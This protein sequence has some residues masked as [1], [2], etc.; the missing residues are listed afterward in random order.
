RGTDFL[1]GVLAAFLPGPFLFGF[2]HDNDLSEKTLARYPALLVPNG[3]Y[4]ADESC[5]HIRAYVQAGGSLL[6]TFETAR[7]NE[8]GD[9]R[10][11]PALADLCG[12][13]AAGEVVGPAANSYMRI[14]ERS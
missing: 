6:A 9:A 8:W 1:Q 11:E 12:V 2:L 3:A 5:R 4:L 14:E 7:Y 10:S 13:T